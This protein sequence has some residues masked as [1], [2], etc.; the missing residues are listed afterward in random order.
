MI[1]SKTLENAGYVC[2]AMLIVGFITNFVTF[3]VLISH[4]KL[5]SQVTTIIILFMSFVDILY[6][7]VVQPLNAASLL[8]H[9]H[10]QEDDFLCAL[11]PYTFYAT[12]GS[13]LYLQA[14]LAIT[15][16]TLVCSRVRISVNTIIIISS[17]GSIIPFLLFTLPLT[18][19]WGGLGYVEET[20]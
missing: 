1:D 20:G 19:V 15:R 5:R 17:L 12:T 10:C 2:I 8:R 11:V 3:I 4:R 14:I 18:E 9:C 16:Y 7:G 13:L 6:N